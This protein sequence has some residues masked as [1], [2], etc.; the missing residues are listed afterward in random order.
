MT[1]TITG[2]LIIL[3]KLKLIREGCMYVLLYEQDNNNAE[4]RQ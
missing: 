1:N 4:A 3:G 2:G